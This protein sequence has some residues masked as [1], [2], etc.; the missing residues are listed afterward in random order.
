[1]NRKAAGPANTAVRMTGRQKVFLLGPQNTN[2]LCI[3]MAFYLFKTFFSLRI[4]S[5]LFGGERSG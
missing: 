4:L 3:Y 1:M 2:T 5:H